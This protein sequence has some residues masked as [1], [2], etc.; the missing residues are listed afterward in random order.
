[1]Q[2]KGYYKGQEL[3]FE[4]PK[5]WSLIAMAE[6]K[7][8]AALED[9]GESLRS[10]LRAPIG[11]KGLAELLPRPN[12]KVVILVEDQTRPSPVSLILPP[13]LEELFALG[14]GEDEVEVIVA[15]GTHRRPTEDEV[16]AKVGEEVLGRVKV[17]IHDADDPTHLTLMGTTS[18]GTPC[19]INSTVAE[20]GFKIGVGTINPH[21][22]AGYGGGP[23]IVLP[24]VSGRET[25]RKNHVLMRDPNSQEGKT[26]GNPVWEDM[27]E[28]AR[29]VGLD[30]KIDTVL[31]SR[32]EIHRL[33]VGEVEE[34]QA[35][36]IKA[37]VSVYGVPIPRP[38]DVTITSGYP[39]EANLIQ[40]GKA[41]S[42]ADSITRP[43][44]TIILLSACY[45]GAGPL[46]YET[47]RERPEPETVLQWIAEGKASTTGGPMASRMRR[48]LKTKQ[49]IVVT[50]GIPKEQLLEMEIGHASSVEEAI[51]QAYERHKEA[52]VVVVPVGGSTFP[53]LAG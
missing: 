35:E 43:G 12:R 47:L 20:A 37:F 42:L 22:F 19:W 1:M 27:L 6:P 36:G 53:Y 48:L 5:S 23:K 15:R 3:S 17:S 30:M 21:Y 33:F 16:K 32:K 49:L 2:A 52:E 24:G 9:V 51:A 10:G 40:S 13:L 7:E 14:V 25:V 4:L 44:G 50:D 45:D 31:N 18:R 34:E 39:L 8:V 28:T 26:H 46:F 11:M 38:A 29:I 41:I